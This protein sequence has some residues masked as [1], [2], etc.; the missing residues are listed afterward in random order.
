MPI[1]PSSAWHPLSV[2]KRREGLRLIE[3]GYDQLHLR[4]A[5][6]LGV[7]S[8]GGAMVYAL[9]Q[10][11]NAVYPA[12]KALQR[13]G[14][15]AVGEIEKRKLLLAVAFDVHGERVVKC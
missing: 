1:K 3:E 2:A 9:A 11:G 7:L 15:V 12:V 6:E 13:G 8:H 14:W 10:F 4:A 5:P